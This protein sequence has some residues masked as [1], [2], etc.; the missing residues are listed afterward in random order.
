MTCQSHAAAPPPWRKQQ[1]H[2][3]N[4]TK[5]TKGTEKKGKRLKGLTPSCILF[6]ARALRLNVACLPAI[7][8]SHGRQNARSGGDTTAGAPPTETLT[9]P[10]CGGGGGGGGRGR[11]GSGSRIR[12]PVLDTRRVQALEY[13]EARMPAHFGINHSSDPGTLVHGVC[14]HSLVDTV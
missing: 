6:Q 9:H 5:G 2:A 4:K 7:I 3:L 14:L 13:S 11:S 10:Q 12:P 8:A 1:R